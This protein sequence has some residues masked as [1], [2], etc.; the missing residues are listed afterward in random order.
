M[1]LLLHQAASAWP[2]PLAYASDLDHFHDPTCARTARSA[3]SAAVSWMG[4][5]VVAE[6]VLLLLVQTAVHPQLGSV[7]AEVEQ[8]QDAD[9]EQHSAPSTNV[10]QLGRVLLASCAGMQHISQVVVSEA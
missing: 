2:Q 5:P 4:V 9:E 8:L 3:V 10:K 6:R 1:L 7:A